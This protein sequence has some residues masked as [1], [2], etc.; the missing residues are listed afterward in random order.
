MAFKAIHPVTRRFREPS[1]SEAH[2]HA[3]ADLC[4]E[5]G[6]AMGMSPRH[7]SRLRLA[8]ALHDVGKSL[9]P[10]ALLET[11]GPLSDDQWATVRLH[12]VLGEQILV[13]E[14]LL[15]IAPWVRSHHERFDGLG[16]PDR[17]RGSEI[18]IEA[19]ILA[20]ADAYDAMVSER[21]YS[22]ARP[23]A[24]AREALTAGA[25]SQFDLRVVATFRRCLEGAEVATPIAVAA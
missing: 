11:P 20:A 17:L 7:V 3:V 8:G 4:A 2:E 21:P 9:I 6:E 22:V 19:R 14:G 15:D 10:P 16:Y 1:W 23:A 25:G 18:P 12:P 5:I 13:G 24:T